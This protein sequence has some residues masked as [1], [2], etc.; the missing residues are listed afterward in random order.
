MCERMYCLCARDRTCLLE[1]RGQLWGL[2][3]L[4]PPC[5]SQRKS[6]VIRLGG[7]CL[8]SLSHGSS[9]CFIL[10][11]PEVPRLCRTLTVLW[12]L[13]C[14]AEVPTNEWHHSCPPLLHVYRD[15]HSRVCLVFQIFSHLNAWNRTQALHS[16]HML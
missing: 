9:L 14:G 1:I 10:E 3:S 15:R 6:Q 4:L 8:Y 16:K 13:P 7:Q 2:S 11:S 5:G 12:Q